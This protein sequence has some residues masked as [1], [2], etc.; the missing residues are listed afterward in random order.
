MQTRG[1]QDKA[2]IPAKPRGQ[3]TGFAG[4]PDQN[5]EAAAAT[6]ARLGKRPKSNQMSA[7]VSAQNVGSNP[8]TPR[9]SSPSTPAMNVGVRRAGGGE[10]AFKKRLAKK[11]AG[12]V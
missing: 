6:P 5:L 2:G 3:Q 1:R 8:V 10:K 7:D 9:T 4:N 12:T 11:R